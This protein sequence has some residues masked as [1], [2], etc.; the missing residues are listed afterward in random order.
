VPVARLGAP[1]HPSAGVVHSRDA[2]GEGES[3]PRA[4]EST[5][6]PRAA[7][8]DPQEQ[9][10]DAE[11]REPSP[12]PAAASVRVG[13]FAL[14]RR[15]G[16]GAMGVVWA[17]YDE[18]LDRRVAIK[19]MR[20]DRV[21]SLAGRERMLR[22]AR[23]MARL[24]HPNIVQVYDAGDDHGRVFVAMELIGGG[25]LRAW[26]TEM[27]EWPAVVAMFRGVAAGI[28]AAHASNV[29]HRDLKPEN[30]MV[31]ERGVPKVADFGLAELG[32]LQEPTLPD[33]GLRSGES[34]P[35][36]TATGAMI[37]TP[38]YMAPEQHRGQQATAASDQFAFCVALW[39]ALHGERPYLAPTIPAL[40]AA[41]CEGRRETPKREV[42]A[43][44]QQVVERGLA[45]DP[46]ARWSSMTALVEELG[47]ERSRARTF[48][49]G[50]AVVLAI[51]G[52]AAWAARTPE[53]CTG[54]REQLADSWDGSRRDALAATFG[55]TAFAQDTWA[56][57]APA[58]D[59]WTDAWIAAHEDA[60]RATSVR[61]E[62]STAVMDLRMA[63]LQRA[64]QSLDAV[65][66]VL[67]RA[68]GDTI[69]RADELVATLAD[70]DACADVDAL[71]SDVAPPPEGERATVDT[72]RAEL[73]N[74][75][76]LLAAGHPDD[77]VGV[78]D[79]IDVRLRD[80]AYEPVRT[81]LLA[82]RADVLDERDEHP[83]AEA[84][85]RAALEAALRSG[86]RELARRAVLMVMRVVA[87]D[88]DRP[89]DARMLV[90]V[91]RGLSGDSTR[92]RSELGRALG[93]IHLGAGEYARAVEE[94]ERA[95]AILVGDPASTA[96]DILLV[97]LELAT[98]MGSAGRID[99]ARS[100]YARSI[101]EVEQHWGPRH[102]QV[103]RARMNLASWLIPAGKIDEA[104]P[105]LHAAL[106]IVDETIGD[107]TEFGADLRRLLGVAYLR[108]TR[109]PEAERE[110][111]AVIVASEAR[112][113]ALHP[114]LALLHGN[115][116]FALQEQGR[117][118][119]AAAEISTALA[120]GGATLGT[121][122]PDVIG[123]RNNHGSLLHALGR[124]EEALAEHR[125]CAAAREASIGPDHPDTATSHYNIAVVAS[126]M[127]QWSV[128][129]SETAIALPVFRA[130][131]GDD[132]R[133]VYA[134]LSLHS[135]AILEQG[136]AEEALPGLEAA[137]KGQNRPEL[138][139]RKKA[140]TVFALA[141]ALWS[142][143][144]EH[145]R[146]RELGELARSLFV[147]LGP[148]GAERARDVAD[149]LRER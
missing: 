141:R 30:V 122:H 115:L 123:L 33:S 51:A 102:P 113:G 146:A 120:I 65:T 66:S 110:F 43:W 94:F 31:D 48:V 129:E 4:L 22:E 19:L 89:V 72:A 119:E 17:A 101:A 20:P 95:L 61:R 76:A 69:A 81:E 39:E 133:L 64:R 8:G 70:L 148:E 109:A 21:I 88:L 35:E 74:V 49:L 91:A 6:L 26:M 106:A 134:T 107:D 27:R 90:D 63:C 47:R 23:A 18:V 144:K 118:D 15:I 12:A 135:Q 56:R 136:R 77:A 128:A 83:E 80:V 38:A 116:G 114:K 131:F 103:A 9:T 42:P 67:A 3:D 100:E 97:R 10:V 139:A 5:V 44:L 85:G 54:A 45:V 53:P 117:L 40:I 143:P 55:G 16:G 93:T 7:E 140:E 1:R 32:G 79:G 75:A 147:E 138:P 130:A 82:A 2:T 24:S 29:V 84:A 57:I 112:L 124:D 62:Q 46:S 14:L 92:D 149:W 108:S 34:A 28:A 126:A 60:C 36:L 104:I 11:G 127:K 98:A 125:A 73:A 68:D 142:A 145:A 99:D 78:I 86:Q 71:Q 132:H 52:A 58:L 13:R 96:R 41:V 111:R 50:G 87:N 37:G 121:S 105:E 25:T 59:R 137:W